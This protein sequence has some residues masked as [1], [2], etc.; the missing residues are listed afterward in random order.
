MAKAYIQLVLMGGK[1]QVKCRVMT[2]NQI[3]RDCAV[4]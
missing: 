1:Q 2:L 3:L 4:E